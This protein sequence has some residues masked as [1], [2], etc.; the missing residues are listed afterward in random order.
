MLPIYKLT[1]NDNDNTGVDYNAFVDVPAHLKA[2]VA[3]GKSLPYQFKEEQRIVTGVM[4][5][6]DTLIYRNDPEIGEHQVLFDAK[7]IK[8][9]VLKFFKNSYGNN[10]NR[11]HNENDIVKGATMFESYL[12]DSKRGVNPPLGFEKQ[13]LKDGTW[14]ASYKVDDDILWNEV[15]SGKFRGFSVEGF[16]DRVKVNIKTNKKEKQMSEKKGQN[17]FLKRLFNIEE[18]EQEEVEQTFTDVTTLDGVVLSYEGELGE[19]TAIFI[20]DEEGNKIP[21]PEGDQQVTFED[22]TT[23]IISIDSTGLVAK[24]E[25]VEAEAEQ[26]MDSDLEKVQSEI[27]EVMKA[28]TEK[29]ASEIE[30]LR[31][32]NKNLKA[33]FEAIKKGEKF[34]NNARSGAVTESNLTVR[35][36]LKSKK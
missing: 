19:G 21:A 32:E 11:M 18:P 28:V 8:Q 10:V 33:E 26:E 13:N 14:I 27:A 24:V 12:I 17:S 9:I 1:I 36:I 20:T 25:A 5:S 3:F 22:G 6:A 16:F 2:F 30:S 31:E 34:Q 29:L 15:K 35:E 23:M 7:T 4:M